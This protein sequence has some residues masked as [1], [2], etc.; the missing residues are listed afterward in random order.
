[1]EGL[2]QAL[3]RGEGSRW[4]K[5]FLSYMPLTAAQNVSCPVL[6]LHGDKDAYVPVDHAHLLAKVM[7]ING[8]NDVTVKIFTNYNH[9]FLEDPDSRICIYKDLLP[10]TNKLSENVLNTI[11]EWLSKRLLVE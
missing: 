5:S 2:N 9:L 1:M 11:S 8:N 3:F 10:H 6:I 7:R 4:L